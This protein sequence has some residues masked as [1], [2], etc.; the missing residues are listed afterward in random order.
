MKKLVLTLAIAITTL[1]AFA[2][3]AGVDQKVL[4]AFSKD[5]KT[6]REVAWTIGTNYYR[7]DFTYNEKHVFAYY[8]K[9]GELIALTR[10]VSPNDIPLALQGSLKK[11]YSDYWISDLFEISN[12]EGTAYFVTVENAETKLVL[13]ASDA[14]TWNQFNKAKKS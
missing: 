13:K 3:E 11:N 10:Y 7:A 4:N 8:D 1:C 12:N 9:S 2:G 14:T 5:F 6:A